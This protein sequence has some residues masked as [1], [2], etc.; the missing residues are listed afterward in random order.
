MQPVDD[1][2]KRWTPSSYVRESSHSVNLNLL[3]GEFER[4]A[5][6]LLP[7]SDASL[8]TTVSSKHST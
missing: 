2:F 8:L 7:K 6:D 4:V 3:V 5:V 1:S